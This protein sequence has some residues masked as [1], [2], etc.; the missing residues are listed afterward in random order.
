MNVNKTPC[1]KNPI[2]PMTYLEVKFVL[3]QFMNIP[4]FALPMRSL[5]VRGLDG[6]PIEVACLVDLDVFDQRLKFLKGE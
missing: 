3:D 4:A 5:F 1:K 6:K 2:N